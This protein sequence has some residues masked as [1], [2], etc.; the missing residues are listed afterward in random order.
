MATIHGYQVWGV[1]QT[2]TREVKLTL[3]NCI[4]E[5]DWP[6]TNTLAQFSFYTQ[7]IVFFI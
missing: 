2:T 7:N 6:Y 1:S 4:K 3:V 5:S